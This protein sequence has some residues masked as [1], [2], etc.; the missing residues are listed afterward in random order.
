M[1][2]IRFRRIDEVPEIEEE[3]SVRV[4]WEQQQPHAPS[5]AARGV[6]RRRDD[7]GDTSWPAEQDEGGWEPADGAAPTTTAADG[8]AASF[9]ER[10]A[11]IRDPF[12]EPAAAQRQQ[13]WDST[14]LDQ[15]RAYVEELENFHA[16]RAERASE[17]KSLLERCL[18]DVQPSCPTCSDSDMQQQQ[19]VS[20]LYVGTEFCFPL[21][22]PRYACRVE[23]CNGAFAPSAFVAGCFPANP[24]SSWDV[25]Q[26]SAAQP[27]RWFD[28]CMLQLLDGLVF[29]P[30]RSAAVYGLAAVIHRQHT[31]NGCGGLL[32]WE[33]FKRQLG[34]VLME[35]GYL[36]CTL[37]VLANLGVQGLP[38]GPLAGCPP[39]AGAGHDRPLHS[40]NIDF[41]YTLQ[42][43]ARCGTASVQQLPP[44]QQLFMRG[45]HAGQLLQGGGSAEAAAEADRACSDFDAATALGRT[46]EKC[47]VTAVGAAL[48]RHSSVALL[49]D[50]STGERYIYACI[51]LYTLMVTCSIPILV[52]WYDINCRFGA[53][54]LRWATSQPALTALNLLIK[55]PLPIFHRYSHS[56][57]CQEVNDGLHIQGT[58]RQYNEPTETFW[59]AVGSHG[60]QTQYMTQRNRAALS[61]PA[62]AAA[63]RP[64]AEY[65]HLRLRSEF[66]Q[67]SE[68]G[69][70]PPAISIFEGVG[71]LA[72]SEAPRM[73]RLEVQ[74]FGG[75]RPG[76]NDP[77][78]KQA[79]GD[80]AKFEI[81]RLLASLT[82]GAQQVQL[83]ELLIPRVAGSA[84]QKKLLKG[85]ATLKA[86]LSPMLA[87]LQGL[88]SGGY[89]GFDCLPT[90]LQQHAARPDIAT[91]S[92]DA[93]CRGE[94]PWEQSGA[95]A[96]AAG[97][98]P[99]RA[100]REQLVTQLRSES[101]EYLRLGE[102]LDL[103]REEQKR[104]EVL[105]VH[106]LA[107]ISA[108]TTRIEQRREALRVGAEVPD[109][110]SFA[111]R[112]ASSNTVEV[113]R[114]VAYCQG[115]LLLLRQQEQQ[116]RTLLSAARCSLPALVAQPAPASPP[117]EYEAE[118]E[119][120]VL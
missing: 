9:L 25:L 17:L 2:S 83:Y 12:A 1:A 13:Q 39:C 113:Q 22:V 93:I 91:W 42:H 54:F 55:F 117:Q 62:S 32:G 6:R 20:V 27:A 87:R 4:P 5:R 16:L 100:T 57:A 30:G 63:L 61:Q 14:R 35:Y 28:L 58:G 64:A 73:H 78:F 31:L 96:A 75:E 81:E 47:D 36:M 120:A 60:A 79:A 92:I 24:K 105:F 114:E 76:M 49:Y 68:R 112:Q 104:C 72:P 110:S 108:A 21:A 50:I 41:C 103:L 90:T 56:A 71:R 85:K 94:Y 3:G 86:R 115:L 77:R 10:G 67:S 84:E 51:M 19:P 65:A 116:T 101:H 46:S 37:M 53:Y 80:W 118:D 69:Q 98:S 43:L 82:R 29:Q 38:S 23:G 97:A 33:H 18:A 106:Q 88:L 107:E 70:L 52:V 66:V 26:A 99:Y 11:A 15:Q 95:P 34:D 8:A 7:A 119:D 74:L 45:E 40:I 89:V 59:A 44:N 102:E 48:C 109:C 111:S